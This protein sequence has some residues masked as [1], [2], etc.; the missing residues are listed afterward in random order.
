MTYALAAPDLWTAARRMLAQLLCLVGLATP[1]AIAA[2]SRRQRAELRLWVIGLEAL[3]RK[4]LLIEAD[5]L[6]PPTHRGHEPV[7]RKG[8]GAE[9]R[10]RSNPSFS[11][12]PAAVRER[13]HPARI[14]QFG[15][16]LLVRD[17][18]RD[19]DREARIARLQAAPRAAPN[20]RLANRIAALGRVLAKPQPHARRLARLLARVARAAFD[21][22]VRA[23]AP[24]RPEAFQSAA[25]DEA[26]VRARCI[27]QT[28][29]LQRR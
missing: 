6:G 22:I 27:D 9:A 5:A 12:L 25:F 17:L 11:L 3:V 26:G 20:Q 24:W 16:P 2:L 7:A 21:A 8:A 4:L 23:S 28:H 15:P 29:F 10:G 19:L 13:A 14:R 1:T 18:W